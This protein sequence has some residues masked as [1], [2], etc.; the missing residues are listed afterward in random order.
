MDELQSIEQSLA[1]I[2]TMK[3]ASEGLAKLA[4]F[5]WIGEVQTPGSHFANHKLEVD[6]QMKHPLIS[7]FHPGVYGGAA[8]G[9]AVAKAVAN[10]VGPHPGLT[11]A[12]LGGMGGMMAEAAHRYLYLMDAR[13]KM[14]RGVNPVN[15]RYQ[16]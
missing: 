10:H 13:A 15:P 8:L 4:E 12:V 1:N 9:A 7:T 3:A 5:E 14:E 6:Y 11:G 16:L 2:A